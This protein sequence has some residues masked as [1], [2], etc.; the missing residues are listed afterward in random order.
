MNIK[1]II[2]MIF[3]VLLFIFIF[4]LSI[5]IIIKYN[6]KVDYTALA[7][8]I[9]IIALLYTII[10]DRKETKKLIDYNI[11][12]NNQLEFE[13]KLYET[14]NIYNNLIR[15]ISSINI[16]FIKNSEY[17]YID[18]NLSDKINNIACNYT[19]ELLG[20]KNKIIYFYKYKD[21]SMINKLL[22]DIDNI[23]QLLSIDLASLAALR[24]EISDINYLFA[25]VK[26]ENDYNG[27]EKIINNTHKKVVKFNKSLF[28]IIKNINKTI[29][30][31]YN[32]ILNDA[33]ECINKRKGI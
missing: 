9:S 23:N 14:I 13:N 20:M 33:I 22:M 7:T 1:K 19:F 12:I 28:E 31:N 4:G 11:K 16:K 18:D 32:L 27:K 5:F 21:I 10:K 2:L 29:N 15:D 26:Y 6:I 30:D 25:K 3:L 8:I 17:E 24:G